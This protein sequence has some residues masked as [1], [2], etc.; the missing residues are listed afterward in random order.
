[1][2]TGVPAS[3][4]VNELVDDPQVSAGCQALVEVLDG[5][6]PFPALDLLRSV[7]ELVELQEG[8]TSGRLGVVADALPDLT[9]VV[10]A[11]APSVEPLAGHPEDVA[12]VELLRGATSAGRHQRRT[13]SATR[14]H[15]MLTSLEV[16][17]HG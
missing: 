8:F 2:V 15:E 12:A 14:R 13:T 5:R 4:S 10:L 9:D 16:Q 17:E 11:W 1:M 6:L 7:T 3:M